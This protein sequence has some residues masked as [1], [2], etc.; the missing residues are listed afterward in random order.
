MS[1][2][3]TLVVAGGVLCGAFAAFQLALMRER[4]AGRS[5]RHR[6]ALDQGQL[7][8]TRSWPSVSSPTLP[9][10]SG[11]SFSARTR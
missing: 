6:R 10:P 1:T 4:P 11:Q 8:A 9:I 2:Q 3:E 5:S 7:I